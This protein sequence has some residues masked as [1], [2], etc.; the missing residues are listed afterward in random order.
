M[1]PYYQ[2]A[3]PM[4]VEMAHPYNGN[5]FDSFH[6]NFGVLYFATSIETCFA[7]TLAR[8]RPNQRLAAA[9]TEEWEA[10]G[11]MPTGGVP[12]DWRQRRLL[13]RVRLEEPRPFLCVD[14]PDTLAT[15]AARADLQPWWATLDCADLDLSAL[16]G[17]DRRV[18]RLIAQWAY[19][20]ADDNGDPIYDGIRYTSRLGA[21]YECWAV[22]E[23]A[24]IHEIERRPILPT[25]PDLL[26]VAHQ[27][28]LTVH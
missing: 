5:R 19:D 23:D 20:Q 25:D 2:W 12:A 24:I 11:W 22:F 18:T 17:R 28:T 9:A 7:E 10:R 26:R 21:G 1:D 6:G 4:P 16:I 27:Y 3:H 15:L 14:A 8:F 13:T